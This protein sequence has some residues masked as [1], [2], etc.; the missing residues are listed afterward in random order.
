[1]QQI[2]FFEKRKAYCFRNYDVLR[3]LI[4]YNGIIRNDTEANIKVYWAVRV[5]PQKYYVQIYYIN[6][7]HT[8]KNDGKFTFRKENTFLKKNDFSL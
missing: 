3:V 4:N 2:M 5:I 8:N 6:K 1:M 7:I